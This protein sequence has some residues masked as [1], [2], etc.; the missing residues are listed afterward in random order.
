[1]DQSHDSSQRPLR[2][3]GGPH[4]ISRPSFSSYLLEHYKIILS[5]CAFVDLLFIPGGGDRKEK[6]KDPQ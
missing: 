5:S 1:M 4:C 6:T 2:R 3:E